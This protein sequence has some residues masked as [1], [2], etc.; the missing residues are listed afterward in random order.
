VTALAAALAGLAEAG[1]AWEAAGLLAAGAAALGLPTG[2]AEPP[3]A[4]SRIVIPATMMRRS[5]RAPL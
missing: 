1:A 2:A 5:I 3:Q 4:A